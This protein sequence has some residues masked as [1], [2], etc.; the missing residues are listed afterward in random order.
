MRWNSRAEAL[1]DG[2]ERDKAHQ[3]LDLIA[4]ARGLLS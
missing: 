1:E 3:M 2:A 4:E